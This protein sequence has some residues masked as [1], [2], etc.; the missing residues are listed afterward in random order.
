MLVA[1][2]IV[3]PGLGLFIPEWDIG[4]LLGP[5]IS[6][7]VAVTLFEGGLSLNL[8][9][10]GGCRQGHARRLVIVG[11]PPG[12]LLSAMALHYGAGWRWPLRAVACRNT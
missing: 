12:W 2:L 6:V 4:P 7:A 5:I 8:N 1:G 3:G 10:I 9:A 11:A